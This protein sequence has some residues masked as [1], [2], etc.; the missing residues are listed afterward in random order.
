MGDADAEAEQ[1]GGDKQDGAV[2]TPPQQEHSGGKGE[3]GRQKN[4]GLSFF[5]EKRTGNGA[6]NKNGERVDDEEEASGGGHSLFVRVDCQ[7]GQQRRVTDVKGRGKAADAERFRFE[8]RL[9]TAFGGRFRGGGRLRRRLPGDEERR[10]RRGSRQG[11]A[12]GKQEGKAAVSVK[13]HSQKRTDGGR[14]RGAEHIIADSFAGT[15]LRYDGGGN[16][17]DGC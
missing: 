2:R 9:P 10:Q 11:A 16:G 13:G 12:D 4:R 1:R 14:Q 6:G 15:A 17:A 5:V 7:V 8:K 3:E